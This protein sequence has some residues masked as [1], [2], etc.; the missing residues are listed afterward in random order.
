MPFSRALALAI[1]F[2]FVTTAA[3]AQTI[4]L[5]GSKRGFTSQASSAIAKVVSEKTGLKMRAQTFGGSSVYVPQ[6]SAGTLQFGLANELETHF[7][8]SGT[9]IYKGRAQPDLQ[10]ATVLVPFRVALFSK[11]GSDIKTVADLKGKRV[12][13]GWTSQKII[14]VLMDAELAN[15]GLTYDDVVK[16]PVANVVASANDFAAGKLDVFFFV[17]GAGKVKETAARVGGIQVVEIS[18]SPD[19]VKRMRKFVPPAYATELKPGP[20]NTGVH[21][22]STLMAYDYLML[23]NKKVSTDI[24]YK[25][26]KAMHDNAKAMTAAFPGMRL[27]RPDHMAKALAGVSYHA[28]AEK[29]YKEIGQWPPK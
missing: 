27:F 17:V 9:G 13:S 4:G 22:P 5:A 16:V 29:Y 21:K 25:T 11:K 12:P 20:Q 28:G 18:G 14:G 24:V 19:A 8:V 15:A 7:A 23:T 26:V 3:S 6:V 1:A 2:S 10:V